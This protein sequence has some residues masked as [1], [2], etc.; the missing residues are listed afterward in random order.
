[1]K[2]NLI[3]KLKINNKE[4]LFKYWAI[5]ESAE[6]N[7]GLFW[8]NKGLTTVIASNMTS[9]R[10]LVDNKDDLP[11]YIANQAQHID[12]F[13]DIPPAVIKEAG[14][15]PAWHKSIPRGFIVFDIKNNSYIIIGGD[16][17]DDKTAAT[18]GKAF[19]ISRDKIRTYIIADYNI[20]PK[21]ENI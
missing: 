5:I 16:W 12:A 15:D 13:K 21:S 11:N 14:G 3:S 8:L 4:E 19:N 6:G 20:L 9:V 17:L 1:M 2:M 10:A 7:I 18:I